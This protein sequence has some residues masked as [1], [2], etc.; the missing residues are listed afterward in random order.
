MEHIK[1][2]KKPNKKP[3]SITLTKE[4]IDKLDFLQREKGL[5]RSSMIALIIAD[6]YDRRIYERKDR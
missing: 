3:I 6:E 2:E 1:S 5:S 4:I